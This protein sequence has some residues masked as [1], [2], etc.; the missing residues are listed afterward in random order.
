M[1]QLVSQEDN[2]GLTAIPNEEEIE[3]AVFEKDP[4]NSPRPDGFG[5]LLYQ[6]CWDIIKNDFKYFI[7]GYFNGAELSK[8]LSSTFLVPIPIIENPSSFS[9]LRPISLSNF[10]NKTISKILSSRLVLILPRLISDNQSGFI[11]GRIIT[12]NVLLAQ[13]VIHGINKKNDGGNFVIKLDMSKNYD[14]VNG[15]FLFSVLRKFRF[16]HRW[17]DLVRRS[18]NN[19]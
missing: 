6:V 12:E 1:E 4:K 8:F 9:Y 18:I 17:I 10:S 16:S 5:G 3:N 11:H 19:V 15:I 2:D 7:Q 14:K 13:K